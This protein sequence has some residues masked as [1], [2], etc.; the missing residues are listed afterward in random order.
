M[1]CDSCAPPPGRQARVELQKRTA[2]NSWG[3]NRRPL[4]G[5][6]ARSPMGNGRASEMRPSGS[7][8]RC[9]PPQKQPEKTIFGRPGDELVKEVRSAPNRVNGP[10]GCNF[11]A[12]ARA[13]K[14]LGESKRGLFLEGR[15]AR[16]PVVLGA[17]NHFRL[18]YPNSKR[19]T[20]GIPLRGRR[21]QNSN[22][23]IQ[24]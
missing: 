18:K 8:V 12:Q 22:R 16:D 20:G 10:A 23:S 2:R 11:Y 4:D 9:L 13:G 24:T 1:I 21:R 14:E 5:S 19:W 3:D 15:D 7:S 17:R 6:G